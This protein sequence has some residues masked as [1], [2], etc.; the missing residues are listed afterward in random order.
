MPRV[1]KKL[2]L[3]AVLGCL[4]WV[5]AFAARA[6]LANLAYFKAEKEVATWRGQK[7][8]PSLDSIARG[9]EHINRALG[10]WPDNPEHLTLA[11]R[12]HAWKGFVLAG[13]GGDDDLIPQYYEESAAMLRAALKLRPAHASTWALLAEYKTLLGER[14]DEWLQAKEKAL[15]LGG[16]DVRLVL[17]MQKL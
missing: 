3:V 12:I 15:K 7:S 16:A 1:V 8:P 10:L 14:D 13:E 2:L 11:A 5:M 9:E 17:R 4:L 6:G